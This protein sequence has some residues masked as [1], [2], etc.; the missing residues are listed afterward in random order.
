MIEEEELVERVQ[1]IDVQ[2]TLIDIERCKVD[3]IEEARE[4]IDKFM[5]LS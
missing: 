2:M 3:S 4:V 1:I 5:K